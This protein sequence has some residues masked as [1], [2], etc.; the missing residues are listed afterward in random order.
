MGKAFAK[1]ER[2]REGSKRRGERADWKNVGKIERE[3]SLGYK[4]I[5]CIAQ[6]R[7]FSLGF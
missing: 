2:W 6:D 1:G 3:A 5:F 4:H 7:T